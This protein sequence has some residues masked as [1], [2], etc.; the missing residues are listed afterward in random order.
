MMRNL[1]DQKAFTLPEL[2]LAVGILMVVIAGM[3]RLFIHCSVMSEISQNTTIA[4][5][6]AQ[7]QLQQIRSTDF[8]DIVTNYSPGANPGSTFN[9]TQLTGTGV[10]TLNAANP[11]LL[12]VNV[13]VSW[14]NK[15]NRVAGATLVTQISRK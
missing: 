15:Y 7:D 13:S 2:M 1:N 14:Q 3:M 8:N 9:L 11:D 4:V 12:L 5:S 10:I 6:E